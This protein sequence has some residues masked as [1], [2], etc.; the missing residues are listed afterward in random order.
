MKKRPRWD[1]RLMLTPTGK[2]CTTNIQANFQN[3]ESVAAEWGLVWRLSF[4]R[5]KSIINRLNNNLL[6]LLHPGG[7]RMSGSTVPDP[8]AAWAFR[9]GPFAAC[10]SSTTEPTA[11]STASTA[12]ARSQ[13]AGGPATECPVP[14]SGGRGRGQ[15]LGIHTWKAV[16]DGTLSKWGPQ[17]KAKVMKSC[18]LSKDLC[19]FLLLLCSS[20]I[21]TFQA[22]C[23]AD[24]FIWSQLVVVRRKWKTSL[25]AGSW[26]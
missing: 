4:Y 5:Q 13:R 8:A 17:K 26:A 18:R 6:T 23:L 9:S 15:R 7:W 21:I 3:P 24:I 22:N 25:I 19:P 10:S 2:P 12:A 11:R 16:V 1:Q 20:W 14:P